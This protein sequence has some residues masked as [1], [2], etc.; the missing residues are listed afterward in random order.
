[1]KRFCVVIMYIVCLVVSISAQQRE[2]TP[3]DIDDK[4]PKQPILH[5]YDKHG[6]PLKEP[7]EYAEN[8][9]AF[10][11]LQVGFDS[12]C[13]FTHYAVPPAPSA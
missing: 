9:A 2:I 4:K 11:I 13:S 10:H 12:S 8:D 7:A 6:N 5:Y 1:M 3:V